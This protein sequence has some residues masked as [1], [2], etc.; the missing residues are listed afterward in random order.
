MTCLMRQRA[1]PMEGGNGLQE[2]NSQ[3][4]SEL[5]LLDKS[6]PVN[7]QRKRLQISIREEKLDGN[8]LS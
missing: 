7:L 3:D 4:N 1:E 8:P 2:Q 5:V 6:K